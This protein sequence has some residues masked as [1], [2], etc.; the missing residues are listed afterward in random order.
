MGF[1]CLFT[2]VGVKIC[3]RNDSSIAFTGRLKG[4]LY[5]VG[6]TSIVTLETCLVEN[7]DMGWL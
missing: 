1:D 4:K 3:R 7:F 6:F 2:N 5:L